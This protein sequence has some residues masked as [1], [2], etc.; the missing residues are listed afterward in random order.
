MIC[1]HNSGSSFK[2]LPHE[3]IITRNFLRYSS[4]LVRCGKQRYKSCIIIATEVDALGEA[5]KSADIEPSALETTSVPNSN[6]PPCLGSFLMTCTRCPAFSI[7]QSSMRAVGIN[8]YNASSLS[9]GF[10]I[11]SVIRYFVS[12][13]LSKPTDSIG[14]IFDNLIE[15]G[16]SK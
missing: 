15:D 8:C 9:F 5:P 11:T 16:R 13:K 1:S 12:G 14:L 3:G 10:F 7:S 6:T 4:D 2:D